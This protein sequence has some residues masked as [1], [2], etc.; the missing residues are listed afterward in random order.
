MDFRKSGCVICD[1][2]SDESLTLGVIIRLRSLSADAAGELNVFRHDGDT[3]G[4][5]GTQVGVLEEAY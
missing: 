3:L 4:V 2:Q 1:G 5:D